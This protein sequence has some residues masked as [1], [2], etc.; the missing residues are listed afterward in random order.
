MTADLVVSGR[1][2]NDH[3]S[4]VMSTFSPTAIS[5][6]SQSWFLGKLSKKKEKKK[7]LMSLLSE[8]SL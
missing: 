4:V 8:G 3:R 7:L 2:S 6:I 1:W 5:A